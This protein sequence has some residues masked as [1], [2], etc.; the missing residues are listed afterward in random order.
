MKVQISPGLQKITISTTKGFWDVM[1]LNVIARYLSFR[2]IVVGILITSFCLPLLFTF[3][4]LV[5]LERVGSCKSI[6]CMYRGRKFSPEHNS[7][8]NKASALNTALLTGALRSGRT[9]SDIEGKESL[10]DSLEDLALEAEE[11]QYDATTI[12]RILKSMM[13]AN[14][15]RDRVT[16]FQ[17]TLYRHFASK[18]IPKGLH[19]LSL[20]LTAE[21]SK[22]PSAQNHLPGLNFIDRLTD[23]SLLHFVLITDNVFA[24]SVVVN[25]AVKNAK[26][27][28][29][30]VFHIVTEKMSYEAMY[31]WFSLN[32]PFP[33]VLEVLGIHQLEWLNK[34]NVPVL[35]F[36]ENSDV[37]K[38]H[39][40]GDHSVNEKNLKDSPALLAAKLASR[41]PKYISIMNHLRMYLPSVFPKLKKVVF[42]DDDV[43]V[44]KDLSPLW[45][46]PLFGKVLG[47]V[48]T[49][50]GEDKK[51]M[52][53]RFKSYFNF[54]SSLI[55]NKFDPEKCAWA[56]GM[57]VFDLEAWR[58]SNI[59][60]IYHFW[61]RQNVQAG[62]SLWRLGTLPPSLIAFDNHMQPID[63]SWHMLGLGYRHE[64]NIDSIKQ[65]AVI[66]YNGAS[67]PWLELAIP[68]FRPFWS[69]YVN[70][71]NDL[72]HQCNI[73]DF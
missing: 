27:P 39:Y 66:H 55:A 67:K 64:S 19:C 33:A 15:E 3:T 47:A 24:A 44:Q 53:K 16:K 9:L 4:A 34:E 46:I 14:D 21:Y 7:Y 54:S 59:T 71:S 29:N 41:N 63:S 58:Q 37:I 20:R 13:E 68:E 26:V 70:F 56:Y 51:V 22:N 61:Q 49:C 57:N 73:F 48:E 28:E 72:I 18:G 30:Y 38:R 35:E 45:E 12:I 43:V 42:L 31:A 23:N 65:S 11:R 69:K 52:S 50:R 8:K 36:V 25:S 6:E 40:Y 32:P 5:S 62:L 1:K 60:E 10:P 2:T 17:R